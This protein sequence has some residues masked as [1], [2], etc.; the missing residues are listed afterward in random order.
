ML[1]LILFFD[2]AVKKYSPELGLETT[3]TT[4]YMYHWTNHFCYRAVPPLLCST[5]LPKTVQPEVFIWLQ[6]F[7]IS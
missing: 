4:K 3:K 1:E 6:I 2:D 5:Y 7:G